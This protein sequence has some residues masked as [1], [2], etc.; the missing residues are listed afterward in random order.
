MTIDN[1]KDILE[2]IPTSRCNKLHKID[3]QFFAYI[4]S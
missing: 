4:V 2:I 3:M 1:G